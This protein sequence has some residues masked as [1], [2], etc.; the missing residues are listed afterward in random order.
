MDESGNDLLRRIEELRQGLDALG[1]SVTSLRRDEMDQ[2]FHEQIGTSYLENNREAL[3]E[4][5][6]GWRV[7]PSKALLDI[8]GL[9]DRAMERYELND[10]DGA[11]RS[12]DEVREIVADSSNVEMT[13]EQR[14]ELLSV[15]DRSRQQMALLETL[16]FHTGRPGLRRSCDSAYGGLEP[17]R[18]EV[19]LSPLSNAVRL[20]I[21]ALLY[22][23]SRSFTEIMSEL[24]MQKGHLQFHL[25]KLVD[26]G[27]VSVNR[28]THL[29]S[30][31][32]KGLLAVDGLGQLFS[33]ML[34]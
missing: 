13:A 33:K 21:L 6:A 19:M 24:Q 30:L 2:A 29:Y 20:K 7:R 22:T 34:S 18:L 31:E 17:E 11:I 16:R 26:S 15:L 32:E 12:L 9:Y 27:Y 23:S 14:G 28:R 3:R 5:M 1:R 25:R 8:S 4:L 10:L